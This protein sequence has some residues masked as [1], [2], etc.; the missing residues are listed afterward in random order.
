MR[1]RKE[2]KCAG[3]C[4]REGEIDNAEYS[5]DKGNVPPAGL[6]SFWSSHTHTHTFT[7]AQ[8]STKRALLIIAVGTAE[9][10]LLTIPLPNAKFLEPVIFYLFF[11]SL[12]SS[13][14]P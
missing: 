4:N 13:S 12:D 8:S 5:E 14:V 9:L 1:Q 10:A 11:P 2:W 7:R 3:C 6:K